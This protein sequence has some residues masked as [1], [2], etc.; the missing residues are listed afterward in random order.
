[1]HEGTISPIEG[2]SDF[3]DPSFSFYI[4]SRFVTRSDYVSDDS[5]MDLSIYE[6]LSVSCDDVLLLSPYSSISQIFDIN[7]EIAQPD[8]GKDSFDHDS[9]QIGRA[10]CRERV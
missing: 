1:M 2:A 6:Y 10:S 3:V 4:L 7:D 5:I 9:D 8:S